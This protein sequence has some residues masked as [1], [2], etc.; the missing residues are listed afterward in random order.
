MSSSIAFIVLCSAYFIPMY[1]NNTIV[2]TAAIAIFFFFVI[3]GF[4]RLNIICNVVIIPPINI[5]AK[6]LVKKLSMRCN[7]QTFEVF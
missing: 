4:F 3:P 7:I 5:A 2:H 6:M 1:E